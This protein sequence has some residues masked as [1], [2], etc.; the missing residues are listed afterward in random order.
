MDKLQWFKF[1][2]SDYMMGKIQRCPEITQA[3]FLRLC[4]LYWNKE[5]N[6]SIEDGIIEIDKEHFDILTSKKV[7][8]VSDTH[9]IIDFLDEQLDEIAQTSKGKSRA[10]KARWDKHKA[11]KNKDANEMQNDADAMHVHTDAMQNDADKTIQDKTIQ[12]KPQTPKGDCHLY[13]NFEPNLERLLQQINHAFGKKYQ[14][15]SDKVK[16]KYKVLLKS[17]KWVD[18]KNAI[19]SVKDDKFHIDSGYKYA[20]PE[21]FS[22][23]DKIDMYGFKS[24]IEKKYTGENA[25]LVN[26]MDKYLKAGQS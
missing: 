18:I 19:N 9:V 4:C 20:T 8:K 17:H 2:P 7:I 26:N 10:A 21:F 5:S 15:I 16:A 14:K 23:P 25:L 11:D 22:R 6:L 13:D 24:E 12:D 3:R 1:T